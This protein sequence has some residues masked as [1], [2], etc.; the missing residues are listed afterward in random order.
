MIVE[1]EVIK[2]FDYI[3]VAGDRCGLEI[4][5]AA[6]LEKIDAVKILRQVPSDEFTPGDKPS[7]ASFDF[8]AVGADLTRHPAFANLVNPATTWNEVEAIRMEALDATIALETAEAAAASA[9]PPDAALEAA[10]QKARTR[11]DDVNARLSL[12]IREHTVYSAAWSAAHHVART[13]L[14]LTFIERRDAILVRLRDALYAVGDVNDEYMALAT[15]GN[16]VLLL[17]GSAGA[18]YDW[19]WTN[20]VGYRDNAGRMGPWLKELRAAG[21]E[22]I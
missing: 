12:K 7:G 22:R 15:L 1:V 19:A 9:W 14:C 10:A 21:V 5:I 17:R 13:D 8:W 16:D 18:P 11:K 3:H 6:A 20:Q 4:Q 2:R